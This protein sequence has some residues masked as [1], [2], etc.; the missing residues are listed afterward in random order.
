[1]KSSSDSLTMNK[2]AHQSHEMPF[3]QLHWQNHDD[4]YDHTRGW[5]ESQP[6]TVYGDVSWCSLLGQRFDRF[7]NI[8]KACPL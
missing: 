1:M 5:G 7:T 3:S 8:F 4:A 2:N 6:G